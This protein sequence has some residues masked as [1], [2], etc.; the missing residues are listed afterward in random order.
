MK[1]QISV[2]LSELQEHKEVEIELAKRSHFCSR[3]I[4]KYKTEIKNLKDDI[5]K[6]KDLK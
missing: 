6:D 3:V 1:N 4:L 5:I 2:L